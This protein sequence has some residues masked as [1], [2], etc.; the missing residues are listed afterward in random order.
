MT[1]KKA[2]QYEELID[3]LMIEEILNEDVK[4]ILRSNT[5]IKAKRM[6]ILAALEA[7][8]KEKNTLFLKIQ[9]LLGE[10]TLDAV[11]NQ[12]RLRNQTYPEEISLD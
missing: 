11:E 6:A 12:L 10:K 8:T 3:K 9:K 5:N 7:N 1:I 2:N 4:T